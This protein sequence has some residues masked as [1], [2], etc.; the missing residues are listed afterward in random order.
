[1]KKF[2]RRCAQTK[3]RSAAAPR[4]GRLLSVRQFDPKR[5]IG[6]LS[7]FKRAAAPR[8]CLHNFICSQLPELG[9][10]S[11]RFAIRCPG[12][13]PRIAPQDLSHG[14]T[15]NDRSKAVKTR[16]PGSDL[17]RSIAILLVV[18]FHATTSVVPMVDGAAQSTECSRT[19]I[20]G[21][22]AGSTSSRD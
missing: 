6:V 10:E 3:T 9:L 16:E 20:F 1:M 14:Q 22:I 13:K 17:L 19:H 12:S 5:V 15:F 8:W 7:T 2:G 18:L 21:M 4:G 11:E